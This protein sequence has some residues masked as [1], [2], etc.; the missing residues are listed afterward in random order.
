MMPRKRR[1][2]T[3]IELLVVIAIIAVLVALLLPAVQQAREA[4]RRSQCKNNLHQIGLAFHNYHEALNA[5]P[6]AYFV[7]T[8]LNV[9]NWATQLLPYLDQAPLY[10]QFNCSVPPFNEAV[11]FF[12]PAVVAKN[13]SVIATTVPV[14]KCPSAPTASPTYPGALPASVLGVA[15]SWTAAE[16]DYSVTTGV[17]SGYAQIAYA[18]FNPYDRGGVLV[19]LGPPPN[20]NKTSRIADV[21]DG[22]SNTFIIGERTGGGIIYHKKQTFDGGPS[23]FTKANGGGWADALNGEHW[24]KGALYDGTTQQNGG[25]CAINCTNVLGDGFHSFHDGGCHFLMTD[26]AVRFISANI[27]AF[28]MAGLITRIGTEVLGEF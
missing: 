17:R 10:N 28:T 13:L 7:G 24:L 11:A 25:P 20:K 6:Y 8:N 14:F 16:G 21:V 5:F 2:F 26:G 12:P 15:V 19:A 27:A 18:N 3:L 22:T 1:A 4:A 23:P 9:N